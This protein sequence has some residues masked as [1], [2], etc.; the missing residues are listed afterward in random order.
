MNHIIVLFG[1]KVGPGLGNSHALLQRLFEKWGDT[2][3]YG[4]MLAYDANRALP[5]TLICCPTM[6]F[7]FCVFCVLLARAG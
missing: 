3:Q 7:S 6:L 2:K 4:S 5:W 1:S